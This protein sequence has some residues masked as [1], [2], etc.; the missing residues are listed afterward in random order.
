LVFGVPAAGYD[1]EG[2][3]S[4]IGDAAGGVC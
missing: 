4:E 1:S 2:D 3:G